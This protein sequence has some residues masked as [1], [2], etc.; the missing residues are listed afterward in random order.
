MALVK[1]DMG[2]LLVQ[3]ESFGKV[4]KVAFHSSI[5]TNNKQLWQELPLLLP[6]LL[7]TC[8]L[9]S[10]CLRNKIVDQSC[11]WDYD[12]YCLVGQ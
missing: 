8:E 2:Q 4:E 1:E 9:M 3:L 6:L 11:K 10:L 7:L 5:G 12:N